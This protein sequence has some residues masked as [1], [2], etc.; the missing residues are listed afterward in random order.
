MTSDVILNRSD[1]FLH[2]MERA[3]TQALLGQVAKPTFDQVEP[4]TGRGRE[5]QVQARMNAQPVLDIRMLMGGV[6][7]HDQVQVQA[8]G[9]LLVDA[10]QEAN[11]G[12]E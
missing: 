5:V 10:L 3:A 1:Q 6:V 7:I 11:E 4:G 9:C 8:A 2:A 12:R